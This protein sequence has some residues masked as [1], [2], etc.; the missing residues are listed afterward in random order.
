[1][2]QISFALLTAYDNGISI[3]TLA[4]TLSLTP[5]FVRERIEAARLCLPRTHWRLNVS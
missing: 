5:D 3:D 4:D 1:M 2:A